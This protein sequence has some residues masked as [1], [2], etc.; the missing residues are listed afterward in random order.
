MH[1]PKLEVLYDPI[2]DESELVSNSS[3]IGCFV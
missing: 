1:L 2:L 3:K